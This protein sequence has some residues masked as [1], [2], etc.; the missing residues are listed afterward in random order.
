MIVPQVPHL[1]APSDLGL[2]QFLLSQLSNS[3]E[4]QFIQATQPLLPS[5]GPQLIYIPSMVRAK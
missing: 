3:T 4:A 2:P 5:I 1:S